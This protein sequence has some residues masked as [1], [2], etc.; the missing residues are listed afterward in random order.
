MPTLIRLALKWGIWGAI[1]FA[2]H[3]TAKKPKWWETAESFF[4][5][6]EDK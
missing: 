1:K 5:K 6:K 4:K 2:G 3:I